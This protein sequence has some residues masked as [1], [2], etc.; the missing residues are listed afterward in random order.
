MKI[1][2][3]T[4]LL[5]A[6]FLLAVSCYKEYTSPDTNSPDFINA[7]VN[8]NNEGI[9]AEMDR[10][11]AGLKQAPSPSDNIGQMANIDIAVKRLNSYIGIS[12]EFVCYACIKTNPPQS[13]IKV[14][15]TD[16]QITRILDIS[17]SEILSYVSVHE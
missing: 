2:R 9:K 15:I 13:E 14:V 12:A 11:L 4:F 7:L 17:T 6:L 8:S 16:R 10:V 3:L 5:I 1:G